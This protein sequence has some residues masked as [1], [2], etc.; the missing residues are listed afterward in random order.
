M[1]DEKLKG[2]A[3]PQ[4]KLHVFVENDAIDAGRVVLLLFEKEGSTA[5]SHEG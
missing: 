4:E 5:A 3:F 1:F 2:I